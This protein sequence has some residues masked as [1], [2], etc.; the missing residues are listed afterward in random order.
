MQYS[1]SSTN[2]KQAE[3]SSTTRDRT[4]PSKA[5]KVERV[6]V[7]L[8]LVYPNPNDPFEEY[9]FE[10][11]RTASRGWLER[12]WRGEPRGSER[13][14][15]QQRPRMPPT[16]STTMLIPLAG[17]D[18]SDDKNQANS[19]RN[20]LILTDEN[21]KSLPSRSREQEAARRF[22][23]EERANRTRKIKMKESSAET[24]TSKSIFDAL[25]KYSLTPTQSRPIWIHPEGLR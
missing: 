6:F 18:L 12:D 3:I 13:K 25:S 23:R 22:K 8:E 9:C 2:S 11:L 15:R 5:G 16:E 21:G 17:G 4:V 1:Q 7:N 19:M 24:Q 10:E 20:D 14:S